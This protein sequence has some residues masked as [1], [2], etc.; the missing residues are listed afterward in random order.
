MPSHSAAPNTASL[1]PSYIIRMNKKRVAFLSRGT[2]HPE[3]SNFHITPAPIQ[4][5]NMEYASAEHAYQSRVASLLG[6]PEIAEIY[7]NPAITPLEVKLM[8]RKFKNAN[9][10]E[11]ML[12]TMWHILPHLMRQITNAK[13]QQPELRQ[14]LLATGD[15]Q[16]LEACPGDRFWGVAMTPQQL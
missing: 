15:A 8:A 11:D 4:I 7:A 12:N 5:G 10:S 6:F 14:R 9:M 3:L 2:N 13:F 1:V 16:L